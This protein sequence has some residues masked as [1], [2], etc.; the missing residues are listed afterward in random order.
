MK[1]RHD[2]QSGSCKKCI[3]VL[4]KPREVDVLGYSELAR[5]LRQLRQFWPFAEHEQAC[6]PA[7]E[8]SGECSEQGGE[9]LLPVQAADGHDS[10]AVRFPGTTDVRGFRGLSGGG[11]PARRDCRWCGSGHAVRRRSRQAPRIRRAKCR[12]RHPRTDTTCA[13]G[14][15]S[16]LF[17]RRSRPGPRLVS[18]SAPG[19]PP[20][21]PRPPRGTS[22]RAPRPG[23]PGRDTSRSRP[24]QR[25]RL[26]LASRPSCA[27][28]IA[29][30]SM[31]RGNACESGDGFDV[32]GL[33]AIRSPSR[34]PGTPS[35]SPP[36]REKSRTPGGTLPG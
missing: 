34:P 10:A 30:A 21:P 23:L 2:E 29:A 13:R 7:L 15:S 1:G 19:A 36:E 8:K 28:S 5:E 3:G 31:S 16:V 32:S 25:G 27:R 24:A 33:G 22:W 20:T 9:V 35:R 4:H 17:G 12:R 18:G 6:G 14:G 26:V 11:R